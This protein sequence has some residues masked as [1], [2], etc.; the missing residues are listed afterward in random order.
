[1]RGQLTVEVGGEEHQLALP[2]GAL[3]EIAQINPRLEEVYMA[4]K[5]DVGGARVYHWQELVAVL[6][7]GVK[8]GKA[9]TSHGAIIEA[10]GVRPAADL[11]ARLLG[12]AL[13]VVEEAPEK[14]AE[15]AA[16]PAASE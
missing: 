11:A 12:D 2:I 10:L 1:M 3:E 5:V 16:K 4:L 14:K 9:K 6:K 13:G 8:W 15:A 7:A